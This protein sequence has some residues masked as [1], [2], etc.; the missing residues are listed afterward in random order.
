MTEG[1]IP[2]RAEI[3]DKLRAVR[4][5]VARRGA[6]ACTLSARRNFAWAT[7]GGDNHVVSADQA[8]VATLLVTQETAVVLTNNNEAPRIAPEELGGLDIEVVPLAWWDRDALSRA[9]ANRIDRPAVDD[10]A[11]EPD[12]RELRS[13]LTEAEQERMAAL[14]ADTRRAMTEVFRGAR[15]G[16]NEMELASR[17]PAILARD[18]IAAPVLLAASDERI[19][20]FRH[21]IPK[22]K[23]VERSFML[24]VMAE[25]HIQ[26]EL[27]G[28]SGHR[29]G[30]GKPLGLLAQRPASRAASGKGAGWPSRQRRSRR[31]R[32]SSAAAAGTLIRSRGQA[33]AKGRRPRTARRPTS[34]RRRLIW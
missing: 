20:R 14:G 21:P 31:P 16:D 25:P 7:A 29:A 22:L 24:V 5:A 11:L 8:G 12:L 26:L 4:Q 2:R 19:L 30:A 6:V 1:S 13:R 27:M 3:K 10:A 32:F 15:A 28:G 34:R 33:R 17:L 18:G 23:R 9:I